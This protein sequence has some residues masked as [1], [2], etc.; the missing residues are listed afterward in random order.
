METELIACTTRASGFI[1]SEIAKAYYNSSNENYNIVIT[2]TSRLSEEGFNSFVEEINKHKKE[3]DS[4]E[5]KIKWGKYEFKK[6]WRTIK[7]FSNLEIKEIVLNDNEISD[8]WE[9]ETFFVIFLFTT[10]EY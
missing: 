6:E 4:E 5:K 10:Q 3:T 8:A 7:D 9:L 1:L 2:L